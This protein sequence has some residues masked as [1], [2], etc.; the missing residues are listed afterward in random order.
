MKILLMVCLQG[1]NPEEKPLTGSGGSGSASEAKATGQTSD[2]GV[3]TDKSR[4]Y[5]LLAGV[6]A[7]LGALGWYVQSN[8]KPEEVQ[9][10]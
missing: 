9:D 4:N 6:A 1:P 5:L 7:G 3:S 10:K 2:S 8:K